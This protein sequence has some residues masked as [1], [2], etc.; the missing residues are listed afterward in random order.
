MKAIRWG[1]ILAIALGVTIGI[2][3]TSCGQDNR[4]D[5]YGLELDI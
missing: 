5:P 4:P 1:R 3:T 2:Y